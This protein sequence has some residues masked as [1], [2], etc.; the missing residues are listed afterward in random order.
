MEMKELTKPI[1]VKLGDDA[2]SVLKKAK[3]EN[4]RIIKDMDDYDDDDSS[5]SPSYTFDINDYD[6]YDD[7]D[8]SSSSYTYKTIDSSIA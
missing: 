2:L 7:N 5:S 6:E 4:E 3:M 1:D 8:S